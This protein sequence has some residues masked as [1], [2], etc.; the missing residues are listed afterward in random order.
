M[1]LQKSHYDVYGLFR[2]NDINLKSVFIL[3]ILTTTY[4]DYFCK[5]KKINKINVKF[6]IITFEIFIQNK[7]MICCD[8]FF[9]KERRVINITLSIQ[10]HIAMNLINSKGNVS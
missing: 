10:Y 7:S 8:F 1:H 4:N 6:S 2:I 9:I 3:Y 5:K